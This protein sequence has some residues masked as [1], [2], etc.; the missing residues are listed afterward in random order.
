MNIIVFADHINGQFKKTAFESVSYA[1]KIAKS[2]NGF[3]TA[4]VLGKVNEPAKLS[5]FGV[6]KII[7]VPYDGKFSANIYSSVLMELADKENAE[8]VVVSHDLN[9]KSIAGL[10]AAKWGAGSVTGV[11]T[12]PEFSQNGMEVVK[13]VFSAKAY[14]RYRIKSAKKVISVMPNAFPP[15][16]IGG[17]ASLESVNIS[18]PADRIEV[19]SVERAEGKV[20]LPEADIVVSG[21]RGLKGPEN[22]HLL[23]DLAATIGGVLACSRPVAD[24][25]WRPHNEHVGQT[26]IVIRPKLYIAVGI[27]GAIQHLAGVNNSKVIV[28]INKD[29]EAPFYKAA[30]YGVVGDLFEVVP[31][32]NEAFKKYFK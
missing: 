12:L 27:S 29:P 1:S 14:A 25:D 24:V 5:G 15:E 26:G 23:E 18:I 3:C 9:G 6:N 16:E 28:V 17:D 19:L 31:R 30:D 2:N 13:G 22:W 10:L 4:V 21:G 8:L 32:L 20:P 7:E 11:V